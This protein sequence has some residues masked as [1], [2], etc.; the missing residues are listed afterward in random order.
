MGSIGSGTRPA[1]TTSGCSSTVAIHIQQLQSGCLQA[2]GEDLHEPSVN[3]IAEVV[4]LI[5]L[6]AKALA[7]KCQRMRRL[8]RPGVK[9]PAIR[10]KQPRPSQYF[11]S[12]DS[13]HRREATVRDHELH[14]HQTFANEVK[15]VGGIA[16][17]EDDLPCL[18]AHVHGTSGDQ[19]DVAILHAMKERMLS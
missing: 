13:L 18:E 19:L 7:V 8:L 10:S 6:G 1:V 3:L 4:V 15:V 5:A 16:L 12:T 14:R 11:T 17:M 9:M 2:L